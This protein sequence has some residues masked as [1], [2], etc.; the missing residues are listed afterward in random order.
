MDRGCRIGQDAG[1]KS[2]Q[3]EAV[4]LSTLTRV[5]SATAWLGVGP[6]IPPE[7][8]SCAGSEDEAGS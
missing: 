2:E 6:Q 5:D 7:V 3:A 8:G 4:A 1:S